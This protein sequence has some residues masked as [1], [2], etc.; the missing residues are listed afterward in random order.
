MIAGLLTQ[1]A[2][3]GATSFIAGLDAHAMLPRLRPLWAALEAPESGARRV[4]EGHSGVVRAVALTPDGLHAVSGSE[5]KTLRVWDLRLLNCLVVFT[6]DAPVLCCTRPEPAL[7]PGTTSASFNSLTGRSESD[8]PLHV[9]DG[10][11]VV[12]EDRLV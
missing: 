5:D 2:N 7:W 10:Q 9:E 1:E 3:P 11:T 6:C 12:T 8:P 4:L